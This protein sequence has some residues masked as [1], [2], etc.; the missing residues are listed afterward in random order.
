MML[1]VLPRRQADDIA[2]E[3]FVAAYEQALGRYSKPQLEYMTRKAIELHKWFPTVAECLDIIREW[4]RPPDEASE[5]KAL[6]QKLV[7][8]EEAHQRRELEELEH[9]FFKA[10]REGK[11]AQEKINAMPFHLVREAQRMG[12]LKW[13]K[14]AQRYVPCG[15]LK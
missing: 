8:Q 4:W 13:D 1:A 14:E 2:G 10:L 15:P 12:A 9:G 11:I 3:L 6:A 7:S 5:R